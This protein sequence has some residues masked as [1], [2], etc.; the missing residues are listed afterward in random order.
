MI[1]IS[2]P[3]WGRG[4]G[5]EASRTCLSSFWD[6]PDAVAPLLGGEANALT[7]RVPG[8]VYDP[9]KEGMISLGEGDVSQSFSK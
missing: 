5:S 6:P 7:E 2:S 8:V 1:T 4:Y 3:S 9:Q